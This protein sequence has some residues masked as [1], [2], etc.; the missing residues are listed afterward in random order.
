MSQKCPEAEVAGTPYC[1]ILDKLDS[2]AHV[3]SGPTITLVSSRGDKMTP[4]A[5]FAAVTAAAMFG[6]QHS[7]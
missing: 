2:T 4:P 1:G 7:G 6:H 3:F 5:K